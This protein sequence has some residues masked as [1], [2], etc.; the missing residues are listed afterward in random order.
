LLDRHGTSRLFFRNSRASVAGFP[1][2]QLFSYPLPLPEAYQALPATTPYHA[3]HPEQSPALE[4]H[5]TEID[6]RVTWFCD[7]LQ[8][9]S[10]KKVLTICASAE[11]AISLSES[12][13]VKTG[14]RNTVF[15][16]GMSIIERDKAANY[17]AQSSEGSNLLICSEIGSEGRNFQ[18]AHHLVLFDL[19]LIPDLLKQRI[20]RL[21]RIGQ[22]E[23]IHIHVPYFTDHA[24]QI[25]FDWYHQAL[26][27]FEH[28]CPTGQSVYEHHAEQLETCLLN[29]ATADPE[30]LIAQSRELHLA[31]KHRLE[32]GRDRL[33]ELNSRGDQS[34]LSLINEI[35]QADQCPRLE[36]FMTRLFDAIGILQE[37]Q[38]DNRYLLSPTD[39]MLTAFPGL[40][41]MGMTV[42][43]Q[44]ETAL[45]SEDVHFLSWDHPMIHNA[46]D[47]ITTDA[48]GKSSLA[49]CNK[50]VPAR[51][52]WLECLYVLHAQTKPDWQLSRF[53]PATPIYLVLNT[54]GQTVEES[55]LALS[56]VQAN[57]AKQLIKALKPKLEN[58]L[59]YALEHATTLGEKIQA[60]ALTKMQDEL[61]GEYHRL[62]ALKL[63]NPAIRQQE[64]DFIAQQKS[65]LQKAI[66]QASLRLEALR[67]V[68]NKP[69]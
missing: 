64:I 41:E 63:V 21:D 36:N 48:L 62:T 59:E 9:L 52:Y 61:N 40:D 5:W 18:F 17:F 32:T 60:E 28:T 12:V 53:L 43:Y 44:R 11:T 25:L 49:L 65:D 50:P 19:P 31:S 23:S 69:E 42:T 57:M 51:T 8:T 45:Q 4:S 22:T 14:I 1:K 20:G 3:I 67:L 26:D 15:H 24:Q 35:E 56:T 58:L 54:Q 27:A 30:Q 34:T 47:M 55:F 29:Q 16:Q 7:L 39:S 66:Q 10:D 33:L 37:E 13:R 38:D 46:M 2:R 6:N 68:I